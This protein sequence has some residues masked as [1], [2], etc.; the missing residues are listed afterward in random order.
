MSPPVPL[1]RDA[2]KGIVIVWWQAGKVARLDCRTFTCAVTET[3]L[4]YTPT[5]VAVDL[6]QGEFRID[7]PTPVQAEDLIVGQKYPLRVVLRNALGAGL[8]VIDLTFQV[9]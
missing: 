7:P 9:L 4:P 8:E 5:I 3:K 6:E 1:S 2:P